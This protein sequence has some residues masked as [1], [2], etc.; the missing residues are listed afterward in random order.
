MKVI[1][2]DHRPLL[3]D[4]SHVAS[5]AYT[6]FVSVANQSRF[7]HAQNSLTAGDAAQNAIFRKCL[8]DEIAM[9]EQLYTLTRNDSR[10]G[11][12]A[13]NHYFYTPLDLVEKVINCEH[14]LGKYGK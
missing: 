9:A 10:I 11:F 14:L 3:L 12:E 2:A 6:H 7:V 5:A 13:S 1:D 4:D 8:Y